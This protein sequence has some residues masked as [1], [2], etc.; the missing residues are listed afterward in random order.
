MRVSIEGCS[1]AVVA[2]G[3]CRTWLADGV[4]E[5]VC[6]RNRCIIIIEIVIEIY[7]LYVIFVN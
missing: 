4:H 2:G 7:V 3:R 5:S 1:A 6:K